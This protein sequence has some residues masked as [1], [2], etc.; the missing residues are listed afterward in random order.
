MARVSDGVIVDV[1]VG[2]VTLPGW[3]ETPPGAGI[4]WAYDDQTGTATPPGPRE[5]VP[6]AA[7]VADRGLSASDRLDALIRLLVT[8]GVLP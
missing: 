5:A 7:Q 1:A 8:K 6:D 3:V 4:G 2:T